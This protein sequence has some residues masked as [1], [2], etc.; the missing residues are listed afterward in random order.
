MGD[1]ETDNEVKGDNATTEASTEAVSAQ[2]RDPDLHG[3]G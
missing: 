2:E 3:W 1:R